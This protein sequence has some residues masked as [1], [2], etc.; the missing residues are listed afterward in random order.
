V[1]WTGQS[2]NSIAVGADG[3][4]QPGFA[5]DPPAIRGA[6]GL[7][8]NWSWT[9][10]GGSHGIIERNG[11]FDSGA[12][13]SGSGRTFQHNFEEPGLYLYKC[14]NHGESI[15]MRGAIL[16]G[17]QQTLSGYPAVDD[18]LQNEDFDGIL[19]DGRN[20]RRVTIDV[21]AEGNEGYFAYDPN[22]VAV[23]PGT[24]IYFDWTGFGG[25]HDIYWQ[26]GDLPDSEPMSSAQA[27]HIITIDEP[28]VYLYECD[29]HAP[30]GGRGAIVVVDE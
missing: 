8:V 25:S 9:G 30:S 28:G 18:W 17:E 16:I 15:G 1:N 19:V 4:R 13:T 7:T 27:T 26:Q 10:D 23:S 24:Q 20:Q 11:A 29:S 6:V 2:Q 3:N 22:A 5:F 12:L 14:K 21:G